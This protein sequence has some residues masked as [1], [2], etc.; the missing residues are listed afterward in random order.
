MH[1]TRERY[2][3]ITNDARMDKSGDLTQAKTV[4]G[5]V[6]LRANLSH[7]SITE[8]LQRAV[9]DFGTKKWW[10]LNDDDDS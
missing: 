6:L 4:N 10:E 5:Y 8:E 7:D 3:K 2:K 9:R 1:T